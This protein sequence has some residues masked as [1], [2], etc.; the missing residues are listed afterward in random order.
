MPSELYNLAVNIFFVM[1]PSW[2][3]VQTRKS[4]HNF[5]GKFDALVD[6]GTERSFFLMPARPRVLDDEEADPL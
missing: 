4:Y 2:V 5:V 3:G 1:Q 6:T